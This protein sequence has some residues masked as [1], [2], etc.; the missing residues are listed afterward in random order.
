VI[1][2]NAF[3]LPNLGPDFLHPTIDHM[4]R[5]KTFLGDEITTPTLKVVPSG[6]YGYELRAKVIFDSAN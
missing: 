2:H 6:M 5:S 4:K 1:D 3:A